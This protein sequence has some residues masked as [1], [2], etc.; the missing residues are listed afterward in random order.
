MT[1][2]AETTRRLAEQFVSLWDVH[3]NSAAADGILAEDYVAHDREGN[4]HFPPTRE[5]EKQMAASFRSAL[6]LK[7]EVAQ[8]VVEGDEAAIRWRSSGTHQGELMGAL[9]SGEPVNVQGVTFIRVRDGKIAESWA[10]V[11]QLSLLRQ[12][13][14][15]PA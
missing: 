5:G 8:I 14:A 11:D 1:T 12:L 2:Q 9:P 4:P 15:V 6:N 7:S 3:G 13:G 10:L